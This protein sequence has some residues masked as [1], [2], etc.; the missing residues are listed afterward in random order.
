M[1]S[2]CKYWLEYR[3]L[4]PLLSATLCILLR[5]KLFQIIF[6]C[7]LESNILKDNNRRQ[8][9]RKSMNFLCFQKNKDNNSNMIIMLF[10]AK[11]QIPACFLKVGSILLRLMITRIVCAAKE[12]SKYQG[13]DLNFLC[14]DYI[15]CSSFWS[16]YQPA[17]VTSEKQFLK[18]KSMNLT[19]ASPLYHSA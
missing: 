15:N 8:K 16:M 18:M 9:K 4:F 19:H 17:Q 1:Q 3:W 5:A 14:F 13:L 6:F 12:M 7:N 11:N 2:Q 10:M